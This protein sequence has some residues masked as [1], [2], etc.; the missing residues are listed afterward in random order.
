MVVKIILKQWN[1]EIKKPLTNVNLI[2]TAT[3]KQIIFLQAVND[4]DSVSL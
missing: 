4:P 1:N 2:D 3:D